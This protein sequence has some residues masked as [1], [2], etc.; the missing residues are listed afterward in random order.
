MIEAVRLCSVGRSSGARGG[1][2]LRGPPD[3]DGRLAALLPREAREQPSR[4]EQQSPPRA[5]CKAVSGESQKRV[6]FSRL[7]QCRAGGRFRV[8]PRVG[9]G[10][11]RRRELRERLEERPWEL[12]RGREAGFSVI[13]VQVKF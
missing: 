5:V 8:V 11:S 9:I 10:P 7:L 13:W 12:P 4:R 1:S 6:V 2:G 3:P